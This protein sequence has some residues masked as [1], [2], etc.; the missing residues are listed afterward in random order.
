MNPVLFR[1]SK[2]VEPLEVNLPKSSQVEVVAPTQRQVD[3]NLQLLEEREDVSCQQ[4]AVT[5][6]HADV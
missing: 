3:Q 2:R 6:T 4:S 5:E 1:T